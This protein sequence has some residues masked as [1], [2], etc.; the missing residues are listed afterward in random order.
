M[1]RVISGTASLADT[2]SFD[3]VGAD[4][5]R[6]VESALQTA[7][8]AGVV[9]PKRSSPLS[10]FREALATSIHAIETHHRGPLF[11]EF[12]LK[13]PYEDTG[14]IPT[15]L[16]GERLP[17]A[18][19][20]SVITFIY[21]HMVNCFKGVVME[22]LAVSACVRLLKQLQRD[23]ELPAN[24]RL[25][26]GDV[27]GVHRS[28]GEGLLKGADLYM[29]IEDHRPDAAPGIVI[30]GMVEVKS[31][32]QSGR[33][34]REQLDRHIRRSEEG[35]RVAGEDYL[36]DHVHVGFGPS[37]R[38]LR[39]TVLPS[40]WSLP[41]AFRFETSPHGR[42]LHI[43]PGVPHRN[44]DEITMPGDDGWRII[45]RW[46]KEALAQAAYEM[47]FWYMEKVGEVIYSQDRPKGWEEMSTGEAGRNAAKMMLYYAILRCRTPRETQRA[48]A[49]YN[50]YGFGYALGMNYRNAEGRREM[51]WSQDLDEILSA[52]KT[53]S[54][55]S[56][57]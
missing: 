18:E 10:I 22:L 41:R 26:V 5:G 46:S 50:T 54:G 8:S 28:R 56:L 20:A 16:I 7:L 43:D 13:G 19:V 40:D 48:I 38:V 53:K 30:A 32:F 21:S 6:D 27:V 4:L 3:L 24:T 23:S 57:R 34:L 36:R 39:I 55:C 12:L 14:A 11:Q 44:D 15:E 33:R 49:L 29:L 25:Y 1:K 37:R 2:V 9:F 17:D 47:T 45:L 52:G 51:L 42:L 31:Y 35:L